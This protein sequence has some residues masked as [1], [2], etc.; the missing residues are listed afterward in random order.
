[1]DRSDIIVIV[2]Q[3]LD[4]VTAFDES[5]VDNVDLID[6]SLDE[7]AKKLLLTVP[8]HL[9]R[10]ITFDTSNLVRLP[11]DY[12][13]GYIFLPTDFL[14]LHTFKMKD[15][16]RVV[17]EPIDQQHPK[18]NLQK[19]KFTRG[20]IAKP[21]ACICWRIPDTDEGSTSTPGPGMQPDPYAPIKVLE[22]YSVPYENVPLGSPDP[23]HIVE[24]SLYVPVTLPEDLQDHLIDP[25]CWLC[26]GDIL[27]ILSMPEQ[28]AICFQHVQKFIKD[29]TF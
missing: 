7:A 16:L 11:P 5:I 21:V 6:P 23:Y 20:G 29:N 12:K 3:K 28:A 15:W 27:T 18:Y 25:L 4:E 9:V 1:M 24:Q 10:P 14:R 22:Y 13:T 2:R 26:A 19:N 17:N 8:L